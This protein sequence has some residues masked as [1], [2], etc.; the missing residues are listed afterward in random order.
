MFF[1]F[2]IAVEK[3]ERTSLGYEKIENLPDFSG[4]WNCK[5]L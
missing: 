4:L 3:M 2:R 1:L 5:S